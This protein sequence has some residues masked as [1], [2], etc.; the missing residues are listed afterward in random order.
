MGFG[1]N[2]NFSTL[3]LRYKLCRMNVR[4]LAAGFLGEPVFLPFFFVNLMICARQTRE[5]RKLVS[6]LSLPEQAN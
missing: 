5:L 3:C 6:L 2:T 4:V 1:F